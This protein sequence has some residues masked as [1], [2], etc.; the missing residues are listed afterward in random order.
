M[1]WGWVTLVST[2]ENLVIRRGRHEKLIAGKPE[3]LQESPYLL[4]I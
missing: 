2:F 4:V 1:S 3:A